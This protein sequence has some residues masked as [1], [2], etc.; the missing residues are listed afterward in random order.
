MSTLIVLKRNDFVSNEDPLSQRLYLWIFELEKPSTLILNAKWTIIIFRGS[1]T[2][3]A[4][5]RSGRTIYHFNTI[6]IKCQRIGY[7][8]YIHITT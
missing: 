7:L 8:D 4:M 5:A 2:I 6:T 3:F 1:H